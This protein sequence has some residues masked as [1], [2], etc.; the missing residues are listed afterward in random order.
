MKNNCVLIILVTV[1][2][3]GC[4]SS[5]YINRMVDDGEGKGG[6][7]KRFFA[8]GHFCGAGYP[9][10]QD[11][12]DADGTVRRTL[13]TFYPPMDDLDALCYAH[14]YCYDFEQGNNVSC[15]DVFH[16]MVIRNQ[17]NYKGEGCWNVATDVVIAFFGKN[18]EEGNTPIETTANK[19]VHT[20]LGLPTAAFWAVLKFP[21]MP[22][23]ADAEEGTCNLTETP[24]Y[25]AV[26]S[27][28]EHLYNDA[29][30]NDAHIPIK[31]PVP[32]TL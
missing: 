22:F 3:S 27:E 2:L 13:D 25:E 11:V 7:V 14:D 9:V 4:I 16:T 31:I 20:T 6:Q 24:N 30:F 21:L 29:L 26:Y 17:S 15:D 18:W 12:K 32:S 10:N 1:L 28:F 19:I 5:P 23:L 8:Y